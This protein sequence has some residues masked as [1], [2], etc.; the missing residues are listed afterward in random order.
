MLIVDTMLV[1]GLRSRKDELKRVLADYRVVL[2]MKQRTEESPDYQHRFAGVEV[3]IVRGLTRAYL[4]EHGLEC[5]DIAPHLDRN[6]FFSHSK[7]GPVPKALLRLLESVIPYRSRTILRQKVVS[8]MFAHLKF[9][10]TPA[11][12][13]IFKRLHRIYDGDLKQISSLVGQNWV[14]IARFNQ[15]INFPKRKGRFDSSEIKRLIQSV[16]R[17]ASLPRA[18]FSELPL[19]KIPW[20]QVAPLMDNG[21][22]P[23]SYNVCIYSHYECAV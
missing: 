19:R 22:I 12:E 13:S 15:N 6:Y 23:D 16:R 9:R 8:I 3:R 18:K 1:G 10:A 14:E 4:L 7:V 5:I 11:F 2:R 20:T 21:R 17:V